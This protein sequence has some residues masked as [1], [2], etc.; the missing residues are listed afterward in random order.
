[1]KLRWRDLNW[2]EHEEWFEDMESIVVQHEIDHL[3]GVL[4]IDR[5]SRL[6]QD[7]F[8][9]NARKTRRQYEKGFK[10]ALHQMKKKFRD[11]I[12]IAKKHEAA[13]REKKKN[14]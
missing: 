10:R 13:V 12:D 2:V 6:K 3:F 14:D 7:M 9:L 4:F 1:V 8:K 11:P 5:L